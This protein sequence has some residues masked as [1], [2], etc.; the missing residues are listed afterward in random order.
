MT[1][2]TEEEQEQEEEEAEER[3]PEWEVGASSLSSM[4]EDSKGQSV[5]GAIL[6][7]VLMLLF[8]PSTSWGSRPRRRHVV[9]MPPVHPIRSPSSLPPSSYFPPPA[10]APPARAAATT[11]A[12]T[13]APPPHV[14][15]KFGSRC[16]LVCSSRP[17]RPD[18]EAL[19]QLAAELA[20]WQAWPTQ[21][22]TS[23]RSSPS[24]PPLP[25]AQSPGC[26]CAR[27]QPRHSGTRRST[28]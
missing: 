13:T 26:A 25:S 5:L 8:A 1:E 24:L 12:A 22:P 11:A 21:F 23:Y 6:V 10:P 7:M 15:G 4:D 9:L 3:R 2:G 16:L 27:T 19:F 18:E 28:G 14:R 17:P 20:Q